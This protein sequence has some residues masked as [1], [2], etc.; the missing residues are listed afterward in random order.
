MRSIYFKIY[1]NENINCFVILTRLNW[2]GATKNEQKTNLDVTS[3]NELD[4]ILVKYV[5][6]RF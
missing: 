5:V 1:D 4:L 2:S 3:I 6:N